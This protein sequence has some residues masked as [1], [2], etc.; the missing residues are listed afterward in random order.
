M[1]NLET[2]KKLFIYILIIMISPFLCLWYIKMLASVLSASNLRFLGKD[3]TFWFHNLSNCLNL[4]IL[5][6]SW[7]TK[8]NFIDLNISTPSSK[9]MKMRKL[10]LLNR[11]FR[12]ALTISICL[13]IS[14]KRHAIAKNVQS[15]FYL[16]IRENILLKITPYT[17]KKS[18]TM[19]CTL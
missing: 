16:I 3:T 10:L 6:R 8:P 19:S 11:L 15:D 1:Q 14:P 4:Y 5:Q 12:Y 7:H 18:C 9:L 13:M 17:W 2:N